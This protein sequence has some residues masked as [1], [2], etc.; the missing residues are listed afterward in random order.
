[1]FH[2][3]IG[4]GAAGVP[5]AVWVWPWAWVVRALVLVTWIRLGIGLGSCVWGS[6]RAVASAKIGTYEV[7]GGQG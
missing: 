4:G 6:A 7:D 3:N 1:M 2:V 5:G